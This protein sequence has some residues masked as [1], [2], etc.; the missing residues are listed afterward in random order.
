MSRETLP[1]G[2]VVTGGPTDVKGKITLSQRELKEI[3]ETMYKDFLGAKQEGKI[4]LSYS[5]DT[6]M[7]DSYNT[8]RTLRKA[9]IDTEHRLGKISKLEHAALNELREKMMIAIMQMD[10]SGLD[11]YGVQYIDSNIAKV[12]ASQGDSTDDRLLIP[13]HRKN[14]VKFNSNILKK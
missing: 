11:K 1:D 8:L 3:K 14:I 9:D 13:N 7:R 6:W 4:A 10:T 12:A 5:F 2:R